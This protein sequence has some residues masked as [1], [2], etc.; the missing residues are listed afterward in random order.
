[1]AMAKKPEPDVDVVAPPPPCLH[2]EHRLGTHGGL[3]KHQRVCLNCGE[4]V[5]VRRRRKS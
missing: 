1:M 5:L 3:R 4:V 2:P